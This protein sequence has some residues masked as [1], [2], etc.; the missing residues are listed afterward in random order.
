MDGALVDAVTTC[1]V[2]GCE[3]GKR[4][5]GAAYCEMH[6]YRVR[7][8]GS[9]GGAERIYPTAPGVCTVPGCEGKRRSSG[10]AYC[11]LH[12]ERVRRTGVPDAPQPFVPDPCPV[13]GCER[14]VQ[15]RGMCK[16]HAT[17]MRRHGDPN[18]SIKQADRNFP[19]GEESHAWTG[20]DATYAGIHQRLR[21]MRGA[22]SEHA[23]VDCASP[24]RQWS[25]NHA[26]PEGRLDEA[27][28]LP[29]STDL[30]HYDPRC[31]PCHKKHDLARIKAADAARRAEYEH[32]SPSDLHHA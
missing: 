31:V 11:Q 6:Y 28:G 29:Y 12:Y 24:A 22:A 3:R 4:S 2:D 5:P 32:G 23:C 21:R 10:V 26:D 16:M 1:E 18:V 17:R 13:D 20:D 19:R 9:T 8:T 30:D 7:R 14:H 15:E 25:Y 27:T